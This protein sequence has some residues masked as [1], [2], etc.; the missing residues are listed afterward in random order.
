MKIKVISIVLLAVI[1]GC[2]EKPAQGKLV[3]LTGL[4]VSPTSLS[5]GLG[6]T[7][8]S[9]Q[10][11]VTAVPE[12]A[13][14]VTFAW[15]SSNADIADVSQDGMV[16]AKGAGST[17][18][19]VTAHT[20]KEP[21]SRVVPVTVVDYDLMTEFILAAEVTN[22]QARNMRIDTTDLATTYLTWLNVWDGSTESWWSPVSSSG[23]KIIYD[24]I[25]TTT[26]SLDW[27]N[28]TL[29]QFYLQ[30]VKAAGINAIVL[31]LTNGV[32]WAGACNAIR[33]FAA[34][35]NMKYAVAIFISNMADFEAKAK[36][37]THT[38]TRMSRMATLTFTKTASL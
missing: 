30:Q 20:A 17:M 33:D 19:T 3:E 7:P 13:A 9:Q 29:R 32:G 27:N 8:E 4:S 38:P 10:I 1:S 6:G 36:S 21:M 35:N 18:I 14:D 31:D 11:T 15:K 22:R 23:V 25:S 2:A 28:S 37:V 26:R 16:T 34:N 12:D 24:G 5:L